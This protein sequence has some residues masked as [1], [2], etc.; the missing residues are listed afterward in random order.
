[1]VEH[2]E[3]S[4]HESRCTPVPNCAFQD[5][6]PAT[7]S[8]SWPIESNTSTLIIMIFNPLEREDQGNTT[9]HSKS[10]AFVQPLLPMTVRQ[11]NILLTR[12]EDLAGIG[13]VSVVGRVVRVKEMVGRTLVVI[14]DETGV[15]TVIE[16]QG[17]AEEGYFR[18]VLQVRTEKEEPVLYSLRRDSVVDF[19]QIQYHMVTAMTMAL[20][21]PQLQT[22]PLNI[23]K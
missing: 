12:K 21:M 6:S 5:R 9:N 23:L 13:K 17:Q 22:E 14:T 19:N 18:W 8:C 10:K 1:M 11:V 15:L 2:S 3:K 16:N 7:V 20:K 4:L